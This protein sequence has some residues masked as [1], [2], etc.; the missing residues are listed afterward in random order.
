MKV[1]PSGVVMFGECSIQT[2]SCVAREAAPIT[3]I[4]TVP[5]RQQVDVCGACLE[6]QMRTGAWA[7]GGARVRAQVPS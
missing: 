5:G 3:A 1:E 6:E 7:V 4:W 2:D